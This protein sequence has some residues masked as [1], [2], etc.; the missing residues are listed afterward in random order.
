MKA[1]RNSSALQPAIPLRRKRL[2]VEERLVFV[3]IELA[4]VRRRRAILQIAAMAVSR[5]LVELESFEARIRLDESKIVPSIGLSNV[6]PPIRRRTTIRCGFLKI[7]DQIRHWTA[8]EER[9]M[10]T[11]GHPSKFFL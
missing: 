5:S 4:P 3:D 9:R 1:R 11:R 8:F 6:M 2:V 7:V 10:E